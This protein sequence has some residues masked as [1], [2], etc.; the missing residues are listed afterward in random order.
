MCGCPSCLTLE[1][2]QLVI[3][4]NITLPRDSMCPEPR[5]AFQSGHQTFK[6]PRIHHSSNE[7][8]FSCRGFNIIKC[9]NKPCCADI[10]FICKYIRTNTNNIC[11]ICIFA[12][13][14]CIFVYSPK[15]EQLPRK[16]QGGLTK[17][18]STIGVD[19]RLSLEKLMHKLSYMRFL[20]R[21]TI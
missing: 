3:I 17:E 1:V 16:Q 8:G 2:N 20:P 11:F 18:M 15:R 9:D 5:V 6:R 13:I 7:D 10:C 19:N 4:G 12:N 21:I 14:I